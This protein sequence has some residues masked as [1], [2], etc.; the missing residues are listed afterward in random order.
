MFLRF[1]FAVFFALLC[2][3]VAAPWARAADFTPDQKKEIE[4]IVRDYL[5]THPEVLVDAIQAAEDKV[6]TDAKDKAAI[7]RG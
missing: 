5:K 3:G 4:A 1:R 6:K 7:R 2:L